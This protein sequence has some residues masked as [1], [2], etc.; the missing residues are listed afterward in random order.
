MNCTIARRQMALK[1][2]NDLNPNESQDVDQHLQECLDCRAAYEELL[3]NAELLSVFSATTLPASEASVCINVLSKINQQSE[4]VRPARQWVLYC[5]QFLK[6]AVATAAAAVL[7]SVIPDIVMTRQSR[8][9]V[10]QQFDVR[11]QQPSS[12]V[13]YYS[14]PSW[15]SLEQ[16]EPLEIGGEALRNV[17]Y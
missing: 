1:V 3:A 12:V 17:S 4:L 15:Q 13:R 8:I 9:A 6:V 5:N 7:V 14:D 10:R 11:S 16:L 2:G